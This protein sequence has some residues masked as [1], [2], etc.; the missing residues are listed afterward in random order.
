[1]VVDMVSL[2]IGVED[3]SEDADEGIFLGYEE[4]SSEYAECMAHHRMC[5]GLL[6]DE[7]VE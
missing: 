6:L 5:I 4:F 3:V 7:L 1:M 2:F